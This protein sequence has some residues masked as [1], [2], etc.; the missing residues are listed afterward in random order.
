MAYSF[1]GS[2][3]STATA[4]GRTG[5]KNITIG[6]NP[7][8]AKVSRNVMFGVVAVAAVVALIY[9]RKGR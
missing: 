9:L 6:G 7:N 2:S 1:E 5:D 4:A 8:T 3:A